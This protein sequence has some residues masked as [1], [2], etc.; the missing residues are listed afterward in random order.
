M[1]RQLHLI[2]ELPDEV[3]KQ[4]SHREIAAKA[5]ESLIMALLRQHRISQ[6]K[7]TEILEISR[8]D[9]FD[10]MKQ[11]CIPVIDITLEEQNSNCHFL[12]HKV[13]CLYELHVCLKKLSQRGISQYEPRV[14]KPHEWSYQHR[15][16]CSALERG[17]SIYRSCNAIG[18]HECRAKPR[19][20]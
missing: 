6:G 5:M 13:S 1:P 16:Q 17:E 15:I 9:L 7:A 11:H 8:Y 2:V 14:R 4:L 19:G 20:G 12:V 10:L 18:C 3:V